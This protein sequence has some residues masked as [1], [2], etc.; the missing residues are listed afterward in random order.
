MANE[1]PKQAQPTPLEL[2][3]VRITK[4]EALV[5]KIA[6]LGGNGNHVAEYGIERWVPGKKDLTKNR[7]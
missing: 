5:S 2:A 6:V 3:L 4:L 1:K 7:G